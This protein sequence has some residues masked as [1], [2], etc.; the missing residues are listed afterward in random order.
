[1]PPQTSTKLNVQ[2]V[3]LQERSHN[4]YQIPKGAV[5]LES[6]GTLD[7]G[8]SGENNGCGRTTASAREGRD[9]EHRE[10]MSFAQRHLFLSLEEFTPI[11][12]V[13]VREESLLCVL[14]VCVD[15]I[16]PPYSQCTYTISLLLLH[17]CAPLNTHLLVSFESK[18][19]LLDSTLN[20]HC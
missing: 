9:P 6:L 5:T 4:L 17:P 15:E 10:R 18:D 14:C 13:C 7:G 12:R 2:S 11:E 1:M 16:S 3:F 19:R 20:A 8:A